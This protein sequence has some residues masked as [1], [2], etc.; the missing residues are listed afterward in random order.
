MQHFRQQNPSLLLIVL[1]QTGQDPGKGQGAA[2]ERV[3]QVH[4]A[5]RILKPDLHAVGLEALK[6]GHGAYFEPFLLGSAEHFKI[7]SDG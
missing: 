4:F 7:V 3:E 2:I 6:I 5:L 1:Q